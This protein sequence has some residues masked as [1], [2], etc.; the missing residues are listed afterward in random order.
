MLGAVV[1]THKIDLLAAARDLFDELDPYAQA[2]GEVSGIGKT[3]GNIF[4]FATDPLP[5]A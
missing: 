2:L 4:G 1:T 5:G 3:G